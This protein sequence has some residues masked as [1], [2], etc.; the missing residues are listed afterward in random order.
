MV[1]V[2]LAVDEFV[3][4]PKA[5]R[6][7][8]I[9]CPSPFPRRSWTFSSRLSWLFSSPSLQITVAYVL[10]IG[11]SITPLISRSYSPFSN[12][13]VTLTNTSPCAP[14]FRIASWFPRPTCST[15]RRLISSRLSLSLLAFR[16][17]AWFSC[18]VLTDYEALSR[19][20]AASTP[21][22]STQF[23]RGVLLKV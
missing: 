11:R 9:L 16:L 19:S 4:K 17:L 12:A 23:R 18:S 3:Q 1:R 7:A 21:L 2:W 6:T 20:F 13:L 14:P 22:L 8:A 15:Q 10:R 5:A